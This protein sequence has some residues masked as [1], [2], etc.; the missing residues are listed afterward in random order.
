MEQ[1]IIK[2]V[3][4]ECSIEFQLKKNIKMQHIIVLAIKLRQME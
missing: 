3:K 4:K 2:T 1:K